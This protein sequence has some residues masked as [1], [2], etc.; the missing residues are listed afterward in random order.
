M[1]GYRVPLQREAQVRTDTNSLSSLGLSAAEQR[2]F[3]QRM[4]RKQMKEFMGVSE[5]YPF[6]QSPK[7]ASPSPTRL[8]FPPY[9]RRIEAYKRSKTN[10]PSHTDVL[11][12]RGPLLRP[13]HR[14]L[15]DEIADRPRARLCQSV[16]TEIH[17][18]E[19]AHRATLCGAAGADDEWAGRWA[20]RVCAGR[21]GR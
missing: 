7:P 9:Q 6:H 8:S 21:G 16:R 13:L 4:E 1:D 15:H 19:R 11:L 10:I 14:R 17:G 3:Q 2:E 20:I 12:P 18:R 5:P